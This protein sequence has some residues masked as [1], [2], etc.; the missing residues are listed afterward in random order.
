MWN[1]IDYTLDVPANRNLRLAAIDDEGN[2]IAL[3][4]PC[5]RIGKGWVCAAT[6]RPVEMRPT[7]WQDWT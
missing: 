4:F 7:H 2:V 3:V 1:A 6:G 5:R